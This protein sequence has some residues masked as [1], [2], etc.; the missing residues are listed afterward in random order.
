[1]FRLW[2]LTRFKNFKPKINC[3]RFYSQNLSY[4]HNPGEEPLRPLTIGKLLKQA[5]EIYGKRDAIVS[6]HQNKRLT[7]EET[8]FQADRLAAG[9]QRLNFQ[10]GDMLAI[11][12][13]N[14]IEWYIT[15][16]ACARSGLINVNIK[17]NLSHRNFFSNFS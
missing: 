3:K 1:M 13:P 10:K 9:L 15:N 6:Y 2:G 7:F 16:L 12:A 5:S 4:F 14:L 17:E 11:Y 8:L